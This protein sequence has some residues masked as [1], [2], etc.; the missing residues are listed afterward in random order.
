MTSKE[1]LMKYVEDNKKYHLNQNPIFSITLFEYPNKE[2]VYESG[3][4][5][6]FPDFGAIM[7]VGYYYNLDDAIQCLNG[8]YSDISECLYRAAFICCLFP[9]VY[10]SCI[11]E[12]RMY[13]VWDNEKQGFFQQEEPKL[14]NHV[15]RI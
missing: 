15:A 12:Q 3:K 4:H 8:N 11:P 10:L 7:D 13:F 6:G 1:S 2:Y 9:G 14:F 5:S